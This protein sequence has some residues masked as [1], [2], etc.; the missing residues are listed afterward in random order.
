VNSG[1]ERFSK[2]QKAGLH[3]HV[4]TANSLPFDSAT[5]DFVF[6]GFCL[7]LVD[8][9]EIFQAVAEADRVLKKGGFLAILD[10]DPGQ[11]HKRIYRHKEGIYSYK[12]SHADFFTAGGQYY[13]VAKESF[14]H[15]GTQFTTDP[16]ERLSLSI[17][18]KEEDC[19]ITKS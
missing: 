4:G 16:D 15:A 1:N 7:Y 5:F 2:K 9:N 13:L 18:Y 14:S 6:F 11:Q 3:L 8:R 12:T 10:F 17:L 19:Y